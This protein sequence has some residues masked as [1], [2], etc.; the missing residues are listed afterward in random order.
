MPKATEGGH[1]SQNYYRISPLSVPGDITSPRQYPSIATTMQSSMNSQQMSQSGLSPYAT[2]GPV[3]PL[4]YHQQPVPQ[5][6]PL[7]VRASSGAWTPSDDAQLMSARAQG[8]NWQPIQAAYFPNKTPN[9]C[10]KRHER[11]MDRRNSDDWDVIKLETLAKEYMGM[12]REIWTQLG[13]K[14]GEKW[15]VVEAKVCFTYTRSPPRQ[16]PRNWRKRN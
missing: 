8:L 15:T 4:Q 13:N 12:R 11:L 16:T 1:T 10:R 6:S 2:G 9:A 14:T 3:Q 7:P 5:T